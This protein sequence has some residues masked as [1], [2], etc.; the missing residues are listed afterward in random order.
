MNYIG[1]YPIALFVGVVA[2]VYLPLNGRL[3]AQLDSPV[4][5]TTIFFVV[6]AVVSVT[7]WSIWGAADDVK[8]LSDVDK[9]LLGLGAI[10]FLIILCATFFIPRMGPGA[11]FVC[12]VAGQMM[13]GLVLSHFGVLSPER[14]PLNPTKILAAAMI[15]GGVVLIRA[16]EESQRV[17]SASS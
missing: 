7:A 9:P 6:G 15:I 3:G 14:L 17:G 10:S 5:A 1:F 16:A 13:A 8:R 12:L 11:Y 4:F 2:G